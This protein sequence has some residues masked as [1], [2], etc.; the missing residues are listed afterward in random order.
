MC[1][2]VSQPEFNAFLCESC[3]GQGVSSKQ[4]TLIKTGAYLDLS[5]TMFGLS[6]STLLSKEAAV[7]MSLM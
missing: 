4:Q 1:E 5:L 6:A 3:L 2:T 7:I